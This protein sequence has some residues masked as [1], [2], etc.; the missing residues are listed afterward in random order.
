[1]KGENLISRTATLFKITSFQPQITIYAKN[2]T[3]H[4]LCT[5]IKCYQQKLSWEKDMLDLVDKDFKSGILNMF[6]ELKK[7][8]LKEL[9]EK[10]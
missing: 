10:I 8:R 4:S 9:Q 7:N 3:K 2:T 6:Q 1:M 5:A